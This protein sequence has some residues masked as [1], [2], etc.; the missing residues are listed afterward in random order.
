MNFKESPS[1][2]VVKS[3]TGSSA[4]VP[5]PLPPK[6]EWDNSLTNSLSRADQVIGKLSNES[7]RL[8]NP[9]LLMRPFIAREAVLSSKIEGTQTTLG[10]ILADE[11]GARADR[12]PDD[13]QEVRNYLV[14]LDHGIKRLN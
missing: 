14:A 1:G 10:E 2:R 9:R 7:E 12:N 8:P 13:L 4:F 6:L 11:A 3:T 5:N